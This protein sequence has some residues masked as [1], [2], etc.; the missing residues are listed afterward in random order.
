[1]FDWN[2]GTTAGDQLQQ[3]LEAMFLLISIIPFT[4]LKEKSPVRNTKG[5][6]LAAS[7]F[8]VLPALN[9]S[10]ETRKI[11]LQVCAYVCG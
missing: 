8:H 4:S 11:A 7:Y 1:M 6:L 5:I 3:I 10:R 9:P 2:I